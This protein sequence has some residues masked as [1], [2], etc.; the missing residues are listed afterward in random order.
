MYMSGTAATGDLAGR[1]GDDK[2]EEPF[3]LVDRLN[4]QQFNVMIHNT[5]Y[6]R[7]SHRE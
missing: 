4:L 3:L 7:E 5:S 2:D 1:D 6:Q